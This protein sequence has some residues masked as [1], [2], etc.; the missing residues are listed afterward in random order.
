MSDRK[1]LIKTMCQF[2]EDADLGD[3]FTTLYNKIDKEVSKVLPDNS[4]ELDSIMS[5]VCD[6]N[7]NAFV[8][9]ANMAF[10]YARLKDGIA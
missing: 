5:T 8:L 9:G 6:I 4:K 2:V 3:G 1:E 10:D 7:Y